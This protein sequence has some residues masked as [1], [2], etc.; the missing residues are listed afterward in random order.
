MERMDKSLATRCRLNLAKTLMLLLAL[1][2]SC[3]DFVQVSPPI[4]QIVKP[5]V[6]SDESYATGAITG[7]YSELSKDGFAS[8]NFGSVTTLAGLSG[9]EFDNNGTNTEYLQF[10]NNALSSG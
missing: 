5:V 2:F 1:H 9:D 6:F 8:G 4:D 3:T 7:I 10:F